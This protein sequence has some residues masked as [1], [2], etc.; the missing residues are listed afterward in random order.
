M[1]QP[2]YTATQGPADPNAPAAAKLYTVV[3]GILGIV[4]IASTFG[5][6]NADQAA[7]IGAVGTAATTLVGAVVTAIASFR[8]NKQL[9]NGTFEPAPPPA[10]AQTAVEG[11]AAVANQFN[12]LTQAVAAG[13]QRV[14]DVAGGL[15]SALP[16]FGNLLGAPSSL[17]AQVA[18][19]AA[20]GAPGGL[21]APAPA[22]YTGQTP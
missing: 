7:S 12:D 22:P 9:R 18:A 6:L 5:L 10:P 3:S 8:T 19:M 16:N 2:Y 14:Q 1:T 21:A 4:G 17:A 15:A 20:S 13:V 11:I